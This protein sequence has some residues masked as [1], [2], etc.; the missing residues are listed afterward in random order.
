[1]SFYTDVIKKS[2]WFNS[3]NVCKD[4]N[5]LEPGFRAK[6]QD[7]LDQA[8]HDGYDLRVAETFR[9]QARQ[10]HLFELGYTQLKKVGTHNFGLA[11]D[12][13]LFIGGKYEDDGSNYAFLHGYEKKFK[14]ISGQQWGTPWATHTFTD[15]PHLQGI[16]VFR[17]SE[18][19]AGTFYPD[20][21][22]DPIA[23]TLAH[24]GNVAKKYYA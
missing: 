9:S 7:V 24:Y 4:I 12:V 14:V 23:D 17:Q 2:P 11:V 5:M 6:V 19:F 3:T 10:A 20:A 15:W 22:Y 13:S 1:V 8:H 21:N 16:P 18:L